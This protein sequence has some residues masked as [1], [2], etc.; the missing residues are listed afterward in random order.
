MTRLHTE[1]NYGDI[2]LQKIFHQK[3][4]KRNDNLGRYYTTV[5]KRK[6]K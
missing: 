1:H 3:K 2:I 5:K 6:N 4:V